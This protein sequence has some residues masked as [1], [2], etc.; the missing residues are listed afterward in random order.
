MCE[1]DIIQKRQ[2]QNTYLRGWSL[3]VLFH[4]DVNVGGTLELGSVLSFL[5]YWGK[6]TLNTVVREEI[7]TSLITSHLTSL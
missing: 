5:Q 3:N 1:S 6:L 2:F 4:L 7:V